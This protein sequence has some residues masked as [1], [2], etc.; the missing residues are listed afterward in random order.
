MDL[1][2]IMVWRGGVE[3]GSVGIEKNISV[4]IQPT[5]ESRKFWD[6]FREVFSVNDSF[7]YLTNTF[8]DLGMYSNIARPDILLFSK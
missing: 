8:P 6:Q 3:I 2:L 4:F 1:G 7:L 5:L